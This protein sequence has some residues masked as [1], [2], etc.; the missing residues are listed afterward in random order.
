MG[1]VLD[2]SL[3][4]AK[5]YTPL[6]GSSVASVSASEQAI[7][8]SR[9]SMSDEQGEKGRIQHGTEHWVPNYGVGLFPKVHF[10]RRDAY[11]EP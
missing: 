5:L 2:R 3:S 9:R 7:T 4:S 8:H 6:D 1:F 11:F 10:K